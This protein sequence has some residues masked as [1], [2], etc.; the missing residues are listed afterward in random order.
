MAKRRIRGR[1]VKA[2]LPC[3]LLTLEQLVIMRKALMPFEQMIRAQK[4]PLPHSDFAIETIKQVQAKIQRMI[5]LNAWRELAAF[6]AN[7]VLILRASVWIFAISLE[8][9]EQS[10]EK[11]ALRKQCYTLT[12]LLSTPKKQARIKPQAKRWR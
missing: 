9:T 2:Q 7:E 6:D 5:T 4:Y 1:T 8:A 11:D 3:L 10:T 12:S